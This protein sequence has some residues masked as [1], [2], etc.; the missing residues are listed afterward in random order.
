M[1]AGVFQEQFQ[2]PDLPSGVFLIEILNET[3]GKWVQNLVA[4]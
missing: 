3:G 1:F 2:M 4:E